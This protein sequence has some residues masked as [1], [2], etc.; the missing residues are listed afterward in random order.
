MNE[1]KTFDVR[2]KYS[3][4]RQAVRR[5]APSEL[6][7]YISAHAAKN[8]NPFNGG[9]SDQWR[10]G[11]A[12]WFYSSVA[13]DSIIYGNEDRHKPVCD[14]DIIKLRNLFMDAP[15]GIEE[16]AKDE[17][18][19]AVLVQGI[20]YEQFPYQTG[21]K[22]ELARSY[23]LFAED[24]DDGG[25]PSFPRPNDWVPVIGGTIAEA[26]SAS[27]VF[28][29]GAHKNAGVVDPAWLDSIWSKELEDTLPR[30]AAAK[31]LD[32]L[33]ATIEQAKQDARTVIK[34]P[35]DYP[36]Y[37]YNPLVKTPIL[38][39]GTGP[40]YA[41]QPYF[42]QTAM[43]AEN[44]YYRGIRVW[45]RHRFG[46]A[47]G[48]RVQDYVGRQLRHTGNL[49]VRPEFRWE[50]KSGGIDS[51]DW[52]L[53]TPSATIIIECKSVRTTPEMRSGTREGLA[54]TAGKLTKAFEQI[55]ENARQLRAGNPEFSDIPTDRP[56]IGLVVT[57]EPLY[58]ANSSEVRA[59]LPK[60]EIPTLTISLRDIET[61]AVLPPE[62]LGDAL[63][64]LVGRDT[65]T[66]MLSLG[67]RNVL[68]EGFEI[69]VNE[70]LDRAFKDSIL[71][72]L[73][74]DQ[75]A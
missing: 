74:N 46:K 6:I 27:F 55:N 9:N 49:D 48:L 52:F 70:L 66:Y 13:R 3:E 29:I 72:R 47:V 2:T 19:L 59:M 18:M 69:P 68:P 57:A 73:R 45:D 31:V 58:V 38:D 35:F 10:Q 5:H 65:E 15:V 60:T 16:L 8:L 44:L 20:S 14:G 75:A 61:L 12:P 26:L 36:K 30:S 22:E 62:V 32:H 43:T 64:S 63:C 17:P 41:P 4:F 53:V 40:R 21:V 23:L 67:L 24:L 56:L 39:L 71:P 28:A 54:I 25:K 51:T 50:S 7:P 34:A 33:T 11:F 1:A 37:A 42:I